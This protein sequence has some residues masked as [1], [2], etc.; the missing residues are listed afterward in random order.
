MATG[1]IYDSLN[2]V[3]SISTMSDTPVQ[4]S[5]TYKDSKM[6]GYTTGIVETESLSGIGNLKYEY[7]SLGNITKILRK[8]TSGGYDL[9]IKYYYDS[10]SRLARE[11]N[12]NKRSDEESRL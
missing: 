10:L 4:R 8:N 2:R 3:S 9:Q 1:Y 5:Y 11:D 12:T 6:Q 7:D